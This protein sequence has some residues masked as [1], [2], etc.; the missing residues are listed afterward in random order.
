MHLHEYQ[1]KDILSRYGIKTPPYFVVSSLNDGESVIQR[2]HLQSGVVKAQVHSG[3]RGKH[4]GVIVAKNSD[5]LLD[6]VKRLLGMQF[7][8]NQTSGEF[9]PVN[10]VLISP[11]VDIVAEFY[12]AITI[13]R[14]QKAPVIMLSPDGGV[15]IEEIAEKHPDR[16]LILP[17]TPRWRVYQ[18]QMRQMMK[19]MRWEGNIAK[20]AHALIP[21]LIQCFY[22]CD[23]SLLEINPLVLTSNGDLVVLDAKM[24]VDDN[25]LYRHENIANYY[26]PSQE[27]E[28]DV[29]ARELGLSYVS[30][31]G[32]IGC[33]VN[34]AGLAM[35][36]MDI[37]KLHGG[38]PANFL[39]IGGGASQT[40]IQS[41][42]SLVLSDEQVKVLFINIFGGIIDC[43]LVASGLVRAIEESKK[44]VPIV[45]RLEGTNV[46]LGKEIMQRSGIPYEF[47][48]SMDEGARLAVK[49]SRQQ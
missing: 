33:L 19:F 30:L 11:L 47:T 23:A 16:L 12:L 20:Q 4:G 29:L 48:Q 41:A 24:T 15:D 38:A 36:T 3:G 21:K 17:I 43:S 27:N 35:S 26:D 7:S 28:R 37:L 44:E 45:I 14:K 10:Q 39:D 49:W 9:L 1:A 18:Y 40:Q 42:V 2:E 31:Q 34:G 8:S 13:D 25:A 46:D 5:A 6:G 32:D 22:D